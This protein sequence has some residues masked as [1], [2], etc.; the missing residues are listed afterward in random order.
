MSLRDDS[1]LRHPAQPTHVIPS[2]A[3]ESRRRQ[4][5]HS[6]QSPLPFRPI[7]HVIPTNHPCHSER[8]RGIPTPQQ[9]SRAGILDSSAVP[10]E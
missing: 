2:V 6:N 5:S 10:S 9:K 7:T 4:P 1:H 8:S 3:E